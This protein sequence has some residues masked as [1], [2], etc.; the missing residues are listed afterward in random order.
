MVKVTVVIDKEC[1]LPRA[2]SQ[3][4]GNQQRSHEVFEKKH[5][6]ECTTHFVP[7]LLSVDVRL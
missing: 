6:M 5:D 7:L 4:V 1:S 3:A 2:A